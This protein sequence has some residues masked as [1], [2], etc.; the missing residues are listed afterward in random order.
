MVLL[1]LAWQ[2]TQAEELPR[3]IPLPLPAGTTWQ[4]VNGYNTVTH[5]DGDPHALDLMRIDGAAWET[6][7]L[8]PVPGRFMHV[9]DSC[10]GIYD[11]F[12][13]TH[14]LC[15][16]VAEPGL[17]RGD[18]VYAGQ[19]VAEIARAYEADNLGFPHLHYALHTR[20]EKLRLVD[21]IPFTGRY[22]LEGEEL[23]DTGEIHGH[24]D[25]V[26]VS[27]NVRRTSPPGAGY[28]WPGWNLVSW[29]EPGAMPL[30]GLP[31][32]TFRSAF[33][34]SAP[35][36]S[37]RAYSSALPSELNELRWLRFGDGVWLYVDR[38]AGSVWKQTPALQ[39]RIVKLSAGMNLVTWTPEARPV[40]EA[41][42]GLDGVIAVHAF[43]ATKQRFLSYRPGGP[44]ATNSLDELRSGE[45]V[46]VEM[47]AA[48]EWH[49]RGERRV[50]AAPLAFR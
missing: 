8:A 23:I 16:V 40:G 22:A 47:A 38:P 50:D 10:V 34:Y 30:D 43:D 11:A 24:G 9:G 36:Q 3:G 26:F 2:P 49:Q 5:A 46:R 44:K 41:V 37:F 4:V 29:M 18:R 32:G 6:D 42:G 21:T 48:G 13:V 19:V 12:D 39:E 25:R 35:T 31:E 7:V 27:T 28:L 17:E 20:V 45:A 15:H 33:T 14:L 1:L